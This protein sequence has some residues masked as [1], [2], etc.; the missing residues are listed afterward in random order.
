[1]HGCLMFPGIKK[2]DFLKLW[3]LKMYGYLKLWVLKFVGIQNLWV[4]MTH[5][6]RFVGTPKIV[7][8]Q[9]FWYSYSKN[10]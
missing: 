5:R 2:C 10:Y 3:E 6:L 4:L 7:G 9:F 8:T 1:M